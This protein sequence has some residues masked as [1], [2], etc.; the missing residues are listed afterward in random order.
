[1]KAVEILTL[2]KIVATDGNC[3]HTD[4]CRNC[5]FNATCLPEFLTTRGPSKKERLHR[6]LDKMAAIY[7][8]GEED[9]K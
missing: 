6:A 4:I 8:L 2:E 9:E 3:L 7:L 5:P 1:M